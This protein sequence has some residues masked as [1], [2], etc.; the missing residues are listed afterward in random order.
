M[1][2]NQFS[3]GRWTRRLAFGC[4]ASAIERVNAGVG[5]A[6]AAATGP[7]PQFVHRLGGGDRY[8]HDVASRL[9]ERYIEKRS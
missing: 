9:G 6:Q 5:G 4:G 2:S 7:I 3:E 8:R 1:G